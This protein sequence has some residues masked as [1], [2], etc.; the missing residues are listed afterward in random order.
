MCAILPALLPP[1]LGVWLRMH[2]NWTRQ[3]ERLSDTEAILLTT[4]SQL[5]RDKATTMLVWFADTGSK[6]GKVWLSDMVKTCEYSCSSVRSSDCHSNLCFMHTFLFLINNP[7]RLRYHAQISQKW[8]HHYAASVL[9]RET[10]LACDQER[11]GRPRLVGKGY[12]P[13]VNV[14]QLLNT[15]MPRLTPEGKDRN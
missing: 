15:L 14:W 1:N 3:A 12:F 13:S 6:V 11:N 2:H 8:R 4:C 10:F 5:A 7:R 9:R